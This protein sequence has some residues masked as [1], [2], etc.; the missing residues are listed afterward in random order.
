MQAALQV[1]KTEEDEKKTFQIMNHNRIPQ[2]VNNGSRGYLN[3]II[4]VYDLLSH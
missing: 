1:S 4:Q 3:P 2:R